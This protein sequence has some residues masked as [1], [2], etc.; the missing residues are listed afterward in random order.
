MREHRLQLDRL[1]GETEKYLDVL[2]KH[3]RRAEFLDKFAEN[4]VG[5]IRDI[6]DNQADTLHSLA[7]GSKYDMEARFSDF[8]HQSWMY[9]AVHRYVVAGRGRTAPLGWLATAWGSVSASRFSEEL[10]PLPEDD[11]QLQQKLLNEQ[12]M[13]VIGEQ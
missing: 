5:F 8:F 10:A 1:S 12:L 4:P 7:T 2:E 13:Q 6:I 9:R 11:Q 3:R